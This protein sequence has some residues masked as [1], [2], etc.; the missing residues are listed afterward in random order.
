MNYFGSN[1]DPDCKFIGK[2]CA[3]LGVANGTIVDSTETIAKHYRLFAVK[4]DGSKYITQLFYGDIKID[5][6]DIFAQE[7]NDDPKNRV[8]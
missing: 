1:S 6:W 8:E 3:I 7:F 5:G 4:L 2:R